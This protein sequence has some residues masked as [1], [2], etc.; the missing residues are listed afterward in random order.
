MML[1]YCTCW[2]SILGKPIIFLFFLLEI[3]HPEPN[4]MLNHHTMVS[5]SHSKM[6]QQH[7]VVEG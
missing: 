6:M 1:A 3:F 7:N 5:D 2:I 4:D